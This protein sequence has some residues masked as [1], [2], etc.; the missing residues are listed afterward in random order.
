MKNLGSVLTIIPA[1]GGSTRLKRKNVAVLAGK[2][3]I[4]Y[5]VE[6]AQ[7]SGVCG[8][9]MVSTED[10]EIAALARKL[11]A[12]VPF[13]RPERLARDPYE[14]DDVC[15]HVLEQYEKLDKRFDTLIILLPTSPLRS[16]EDIRQ[17]VRLFRK[18]NGRF[19]MS[20]SRMDPHFYN[21]MCLDEKALTMTPVFPKD[22]T[23]GRGKPS[24]PVRANGA[25]TVLDVEAFRNAGTYYGTP[26]LGYEM[27]WERSVDVDTERDLLFAECIINKNLSFNIE[28]GSK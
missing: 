5:A 7:A 6:A 1:K 13:M 18:H 12:Q 26:L 17:C 27:T 11:G 9:I 8:E 3:L 23:S 4:A 16:A 2:P 24:V 20:V 14:V 19:L 21:A 15:L 28:R 22:N 25:V 10:E